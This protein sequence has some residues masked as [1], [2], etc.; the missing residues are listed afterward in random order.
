MQTLL[1]EAGILTVYI[2]AHLPVDRVIIYSVMYILKFINDN[3]IY[4]K[5]FVCSVLPEDG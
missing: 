3:F 2:V 4:I 5:P 1:V